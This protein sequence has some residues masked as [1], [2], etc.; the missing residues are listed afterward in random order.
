MEIRKTK[1]DD[2]L[3]KRR[4]VE[5]D[6]DAEST[7]AASPLQEKSIN[8]PTMTFGEIKDGIFANDPNLNYVAT[9]AARKML[10]RERNP[11]ID[12]MIEVGVIP[13]LVE[14]LK[15]HSKPE[16]QFEAAW[17]L[18]N[19]AS[20]TQE[21]TRAVVDNGA[22]P[23]FIQLLHSEDNNVCEQAVWALGNIAGDGTQLRDEVIKHGVVK[24]LVDL[25]ESRTITEPFLS[26]VTW[27]ISNLC[28]NKN[29]SPPM[30]V[31]TSCLPTLVNLINARIER[32]SAL[33]VHDRQ[34]ISKYS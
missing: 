25:A 5:V 29:P 7:G 30:V 18:T 14:F 15:A 11:P 33:S 3:S 27:T 13:R 21:Q 4:N 2:A 1:R 22:V 23:Y 12:S 20:G 28:R 24:P 31:L 19:I 10:S 32:F 8:R 6:S 16:L 34:I 26:N 17:A 9:Q